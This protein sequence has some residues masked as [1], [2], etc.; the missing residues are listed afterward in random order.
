MKITVGKDKGTEIHELFFSNP[1]FIGWALHETNP[2]T[3]LFYCITEMKRLID[4]FDKKPF[5][6]KCFGRDCTKKSTRL[7][8]AKGNIQSYFFWCN[9]CDPFQMGATPGK[10]ASLSTYLQATSFVTRYCS[11]RKKDYVYI[12][13][14]MAQAK[15]IFEKRLTQQ[16]IESCFGITPT[17]NTKQLYLFG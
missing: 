8:A 12:I 11:G 9:K 17:Q 14:K 10:I 6:I 3:R 5:E 16:Q 2:G 1:K 4:I 13:R 15:N 7:T